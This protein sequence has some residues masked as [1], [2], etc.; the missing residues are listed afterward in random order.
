MRIA[1]SARGDSDAA[2]GQPL[3]GLA[4][5]I[6]YDVAH[7][8]CSDPSRSGGSSLH[9]A[10]PRFVLRERG[11]EDKPS[12]FDDLVSLPSRVS[13]VSSPSAWAALRLTINFELVGSL[14]RQIGRLFT[15]E[16]PASIDPRFVWWRS[17]P[18]GSS[19][20][21]DALTVGAGPNSA[22]LDLQ[23]PNILALPF[24]SPHLIALA[25]ALQLRLS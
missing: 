19:S 22:A 25:F 17:L 11:R 18:G 7:P 8:A 21:A 6:D 1:S 16:G 14:A 10:R 2:A 12:I 13:G 5:I 20:G 9:M 4:E 15:F 3:D 23:E 24:M